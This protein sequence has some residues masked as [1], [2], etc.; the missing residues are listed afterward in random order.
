MQRHF[1]TKFCSL[2]Y[3][4]S[5]HEH[6]FSCL[7]ISAWLFLSHPR[8]KAG[9]FHV[10]LYN[11]VY[12]STPGG[13]PGADR[14]T[15]SVKMP[16]KSWLIVSVSKNCYYLLHFTWRKQPKM[17]LNM[18]AISSMLLI[19][20]VTLKL[21]WGNFVLLVLVPSAGHN[22]CLFSWLTLSSFC[23][24]SNS[25]QPLTKITHGQYLLWECQNRL[26]LA[27]QCDPMQLFMAI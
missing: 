3:G 18:C 24:F 8:F 19:C 14:Q 26:C 23:M 10:Y 17:P 9:C 12:F 1:N 4:S 15:T 7:F 21:L 6:H 16:G 11:A 20:K 2:I 22:I 25:L 5:L 13:G 27:N